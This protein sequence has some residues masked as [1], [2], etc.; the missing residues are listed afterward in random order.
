MRCARG[1][2]AAAGV[3]ALLLELQEIRDRGFDGRAVALVFVVQPLAEHGGRIV[4]C[5][6]YGSEGYIA[7][8]HELL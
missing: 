4:R 1:C 7:L 5:A 3:L 6:R 8:V 2:V